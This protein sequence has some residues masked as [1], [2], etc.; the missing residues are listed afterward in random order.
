LSRAEEIFR[1]RGRESA[2]RL[3]KM[4][5]R[6]SE[7]IVLQ[8]YA[9]G[10]ADRL[11][12]FVSRVWGR[13][14]GV[15][16]G[17][18]RTKSRFGSTFEPLSHIRIWF[19]ENEARP[20]VRINQCELL[21]SFVEAHRDYSAS[22]ALSLLCEISEAVLPEREPSD[23][24]FRLILLAAR[25]IK[26][27]GMTAL[28]L[29]YF[30]LWTARLGGWLPS[31]GRCAGC[32]RE[33]GSEGAWGAPGRGGLR[34]P[35]CHTPGMRKIGATALA[36]ARRMLEEKLDRMIQPNGGESVP[37]ELNEFLMDLIE[38]QIERKLAA[39]QMLEAAP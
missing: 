8:S 15:A 14:R 18:R 35:S 7:A 4:P 27:T 11:V 9:L 2:R 22:V 39:R 24:A 13:M 33:L 25:T 38:H 5:L 10:E 17:A 16:R 26:Q 31:L 32:G 6:E 12:S 1:E 34:C 20:L 23:A 30:N 36:A 19:F 3:F 37:R 21:E 28:P 29:L